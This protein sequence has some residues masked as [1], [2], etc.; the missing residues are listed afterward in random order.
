VK[1]FRQSGSA[2]IKLTRSALRLLA[3]EFFVYRYS[4]PSE[5]LGAAMP[6]M[7]ANQFEVL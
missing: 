6:A 2:K 3:V 4:K 1:C 7:K 5:V